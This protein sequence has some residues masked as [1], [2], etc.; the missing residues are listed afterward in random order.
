MSGTANL[1]GAVDVL[2]HL[3]DPEP[4]E[5]RPRHHRAEPRDPGSGQHVHRGRAAAAVGTGG[6]H[7]PDVPDGGQRRAR[8]R[9]PRPPPAT[10]RPP[11]SGR[12]PPTTARP[13]PTSPA[14][15]ARPTAAPVPCPTRAS[16]SGR[17]SRT[18]AGPR[19]P[20]R[21]RS[22]WRCPRPRRRSAPPPPAAARR[23]WPFT[24]GASDGGTPV[25]DATATCT[26]SGSGVAGSATATSS[27][28]TVTGLT[29]GR[30]TRA[31]SRRGTS[32]G[33]AR[34]RRRRTSS[35]RPSVPQVTQQPQDT[36]VPAG[37][38]V[39]VHARRHRARRRR[40]CSGRC[41]PTVARRSRTSPARPRPTLHRDRGPRR[42]R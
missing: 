26:S 19:G 37:A 20:P 12:C 39:L 18:P 16:S 29:A 22:R 2:E 32:S 8:T 21:P 36:T 25:I 31:R 1:S 30:R 6:V 27:P 38:A 24:P 28:I 34:R 17:C 14:R 33:P 3:H 5:L 41:P 35:S 7:R 9:S 11:S 40:P 23:S 42:L 15:P 13:S 10:R 4:R